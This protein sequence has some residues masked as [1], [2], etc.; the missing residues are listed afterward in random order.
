[1]QVAE[2]TLFL[3]NGKW[4]G[5]GTKFEG[6]VVADGEWNGIADAADEKIFYYT[7]GLPVLG[8][9]GD[10]TIEAAEELS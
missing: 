6:M 1:M 2:A 3:C 9:H 10:F 7:D 8:D 5:D 4:N